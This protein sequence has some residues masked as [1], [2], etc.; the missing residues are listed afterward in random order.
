M[1]AAQQERYILIDLIDWLEFHTLERNRDL[2]RHQDVKDAV[3]TNFIFMQVR[4]RQGDRPHGHR[5][6]CPHYPWWGP[7]AL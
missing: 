5:Q 4:D 1:V 7:M 6:S 2:W 3:R